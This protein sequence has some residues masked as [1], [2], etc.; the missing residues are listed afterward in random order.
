MREIGML[1]WILGIGLGLYAGLAFDPSLPIHPEAGAFSERVINLH[2]ASQ[3][4]MMLGAAGLMI[5]I[6][7]GLHVVST[8]RPTVEPNL[9]PQKTDKVEASVTRLAYARQLGI[10]EKADG[11]AFGNDEYKSLEDAIARAEALKRMKA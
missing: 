3:Q 4:N 8:F 7:V 6:G 5:L 11:Y 2:R 10:V 1:L 9:A